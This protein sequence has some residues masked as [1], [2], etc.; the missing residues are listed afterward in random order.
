MSFE[1]LAPIS[2]SPHGDGSHKWISVA[3]RIPSRYVTRTHMEFSITKALAFDL[4][5]NCGEYVIVAP[6]HGGDRGK[7]YLRPTLEKV[8][9]AIRMFPRTNARRRATGPFF[10]FSL[11]TVT[12][13]WQAIRVPFQEVMDGVVVELPAELVARLEAAGARGFRR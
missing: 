1:R 9:G 11:L 10:R 6:G 8:A 7:V 12:E 2:D 3:G 4:G 13:P 5:F